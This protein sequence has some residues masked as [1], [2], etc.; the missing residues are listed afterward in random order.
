LFGSKTMILLNL[1]WVLP[2]AFIKGDT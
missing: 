1:A 2:V